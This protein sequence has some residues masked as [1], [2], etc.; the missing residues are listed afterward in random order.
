MI[1]MCN[2]TSMRLANGNYECTLCGV[3]L[4]V[5]DEMTAKVEAAE[6]SGPPDAIVIDGVE[7]HRC[8]FAIEGGRVK[9]SLV[10]AVPVPGL[11][12]TLA[13]SV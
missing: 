11:L 7:I 1:A 2:N 4:D 8:D 6:T 12:L 9:L 5:P 3:V 10:L 13:C